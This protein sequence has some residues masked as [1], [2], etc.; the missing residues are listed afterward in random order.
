LIGPA[1]LILTPDI[2]RP[3]RSGNPSSG[4]DYSLW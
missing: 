3:A 1:E 2:S 4:M